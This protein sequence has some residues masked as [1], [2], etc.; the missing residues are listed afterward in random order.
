MLISVELHE[1][2]VRAVRLLWKALERLMR[3]LAMRIAKPFYCIPVRVRRRWNVH[4]GHGEE[5]GHDELDHEL[6]LAC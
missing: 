5:H 6:C 3:V 1:G 4:P 2:R